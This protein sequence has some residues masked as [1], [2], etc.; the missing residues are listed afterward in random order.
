MNRPL[1]A[2]G[3]RGLKVVLE[4]A[5]VDT[6]YVWIPAYAEMI[7]LRRTEGLVVDSP[8]DEGCPE[9]RIPLNHPLLKGD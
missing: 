9:F 7:R 1:T 8:Q 4:T 3:A 5:P 6:A 2:L